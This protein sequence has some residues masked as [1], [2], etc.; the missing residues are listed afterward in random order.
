MATELYHTSINLDLEPVWYDDA[1]EIVVSFGTEVHKLC[2]QNP[3]CLR[4]A[5]VLPP[6]EARLKIEFVN[7]RDGDTQPDQNLD[8][9]V[10]VQSVTVNGITDPRFIYQSRYTPIYNPIW[11]DQQHSRPPAEISGATYLGWN[12]CWSLTIEVPAFVWIHKTLA[13]GWIFQ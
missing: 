13:L 1:P 12:G 2:L 11:L 3:A 10:K 6:G 7:K 4:F 5:A 8:K 9:A